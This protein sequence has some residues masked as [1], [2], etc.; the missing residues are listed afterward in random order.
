MTAAPDAA[1]N[2]A[3]LQRSNPA[4][5]PHTG[6]TIK[7]HDQPLPLSPETGQ[8]FDLARGGPSYFKTKS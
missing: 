2:V 5:F 3:G 7:P 1:E 6:S 4:P 8:T